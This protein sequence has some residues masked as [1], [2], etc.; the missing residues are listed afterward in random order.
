MWWAAEHNCVFTDWFKPIDWTVWHQSR[1]PIPV[2]PE[3]LLYTPS[4]S[5]SFTIK[6]SLHT[7]IRPVSFPAHLPVSMCACVNQWVCL[8]PDLDSVLPEE[9]VSLICQSSLLSSLWSLRAPPLNHHHTQTQTP[10]TAVSSM[11]LVIYRL[12]M[13]C[14]ERHGVQMT[15]ISVLALATL[16]TTGALY[17]RTNQQSHSHEAPSQWQ[18]WA[19][20]YMHAMCM[21]MHTGRFAQTLAAHKKNQ[22]AGLKSQTQSPTKAPKKHTR[23]HM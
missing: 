11:S 9:S 14:V 5:Q 3:G 4:L 19:H 12:I 2:G 20:A 16:S 18:T 1:N 21:H 17:R 8:S 13:W 23:V 7:C 15:G 10:P 22:E 6:W